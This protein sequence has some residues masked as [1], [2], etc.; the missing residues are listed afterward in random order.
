VELM[1]V[2]EICDLF[3]VSRTRVQQLTKREDFPVPL[4]ELA[5][6]RVWDGA[7]VRAWATAKGRL[8]SDDEPA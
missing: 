6:G 1:G 3:G 5:L 2:Q 4:A 8:I 7:A